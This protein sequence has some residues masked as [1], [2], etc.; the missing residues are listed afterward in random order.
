[1]YK[2]ILKKIQE[3]ENT[4]NGIQQEQKKDIEQK[5]KSYRNELDKIRKMFPDNFFE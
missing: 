5:I 1:M 3:L 4:K 2:T